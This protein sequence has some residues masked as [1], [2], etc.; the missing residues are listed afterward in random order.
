MEFKELVESGKSCCDK[1]FRVSSK[2]RSVVRDVE[3][4]ESLLVAL[5]SRITTHASICRSSNASHMR[6]NDTEEF[7][8]R[9]LP[10]LFTKTPLDDVPAVLSD[11]HRQFFPTFQP[12]VG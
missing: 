1:K 11:L 2:S 5:A 10:L 4:N 9:V 8:I 6:S 12:L 3:V 7:M